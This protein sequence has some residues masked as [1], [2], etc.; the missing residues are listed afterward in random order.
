MPFCFS[1]FSPGFCTPPDPMPF[2]TKLNCVQLS[3]TLA[4]PQSELSE[5]SP[6]QE[7]PEVSTSRHSNVFAF[8][9]TLHEIPTLQDE[10]R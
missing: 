9:S 5:P 7:Q 4:K 3:K 10:E 2:F 8:G 6:V 1:I